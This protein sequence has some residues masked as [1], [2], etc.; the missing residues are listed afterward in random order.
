MDSE[1]GN[2]LASRK[3]RSLPRCQTYSTFSGHNLGYHGKVSFRTLLHQK[4]FFSGKSNETL[5]FSNMPI[6]VGL[7]NNVD[8]EWCHEWAVPLSGG[9]G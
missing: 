6:I 2:V 3:E 9:G 5:I 4:K 1:F 8:N 7:C